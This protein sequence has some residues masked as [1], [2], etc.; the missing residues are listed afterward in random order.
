MLKAGLN[1]SKYFKLLCLFRINIIIKNKMF[2]SFYNV[3]LF[4]QKLFILL[5]F[6]K[7]NITS[8]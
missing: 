7:S 1:K 3:N 8:S 5:V 4:I 6:I 2:K